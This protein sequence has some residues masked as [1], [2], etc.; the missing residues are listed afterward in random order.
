MPPTKSSPA[1]IQKA[2]AIPL[3]T[4]REKYTRLLP[5]TSETHGMK[6][7]CVILSPGESVG[8]HNTN[9]NE[10]LIVPLEGQGEL[11]LE[12]MES[13]TIRPG[14]VLYN[15]PHTLH[16]VV[17]TGSQSLKYVFIVAKS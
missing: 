4:G 5:D 7:G 1:L 14:E 11:L 12:G 9:E 8:K 15:P 16:D 3:P 6:S 13:L 2:K 17:N 10:E